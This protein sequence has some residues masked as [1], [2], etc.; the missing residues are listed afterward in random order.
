MYDYFMQDS[1]MAHTANFSVSALEE[2]FGR[3]FSHFSLWPYRSPDFD[4]CDYYLWETL[5]DRVY[6]HIHHSLHGFKGNI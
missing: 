3:Q 4:L 2:V 1:A 6:V 5:E